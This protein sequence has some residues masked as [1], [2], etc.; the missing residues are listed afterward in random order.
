MNG[1]CGLKEYELRLS[2]G[3]DLGK[4]D[5]LQGSHG[6]SIFHRGSV[7]AVVEEE[8]NVF[9]LFSG[10]TP[11]LVQCSPE[12]AVQRARDVT[13]VNRPNDVMDGYCRLFGGS[14]C[15]VLN[16]LC[17]MMVVNDGNVV[18]RHWLDRLR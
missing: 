17:G 18:V 4:D 12:R 14:H 15:G 5:L 7:V 8:E 6:F 16:F 11:E 3:L 13:E 1:T 10:E 2:R 9:S